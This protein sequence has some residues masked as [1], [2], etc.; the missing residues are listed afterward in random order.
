[1]LDLFQSHNADTI[2]MANNYISGNKWQSDIWKIAVPCSQCQWETDANGFPLY[3]VLKD[4]LAYDTDPTQWVVNQNFFHADAPVTAQLTSTVDP[5]DNLVLYFGTGRYMGQDDTIDNSQQY[6][7]GV[8]DPFYN[9]TKYESSYY[10]NFGTPLPLNQSDLLDS[11]N[12]ETL[13]TAA[14]GSYTTGFGASILPF[15]KFVDTVRED[16]NGWY[17]SL[18][19]FGSSPSERII[20]QPALLGG[21]LL[22]PTFTPSS[23]ICGQGGGTTF[24]GVYYE[25]GTGFIRQIFDIT[26][27]RYGTVDG[28]PAEIIEIRDDKYY[29]GMPAPKA[30]F[31]GGR[32]TGAKI[33]TQVGTGE[34]V[35]FRIYPAFYFKSMTAEWWD[36]PDQMPEFQSDDN[37][38]W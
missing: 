36:D 29:L 2:F 3:N 25:T 17:V 15:E 32:E 28:E 38:N 37:C 8:K 5:L 18:L 21:V 31:H 33:S 14:T 6:L 35:N 24:V 4:E 22:T 23:N 9:K 16:E 34:F 13:T 27:L 12:I 7:Y 19:T 10:H 11:T 26:N 30:V 1:V 20:T